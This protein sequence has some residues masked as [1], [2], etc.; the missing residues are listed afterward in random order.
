MARH[1]RYD[2]RV[3]GAQVRQPFFEA[4][5]SAAPIPRCCSHRQRDMAY[6]GVGEGAACGCTDLCEQRDLAS[7]EV[8]AACQAVHGSFP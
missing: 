2:C 8:S 1:Y 3:C 7:D 5:P 4:L 6:K